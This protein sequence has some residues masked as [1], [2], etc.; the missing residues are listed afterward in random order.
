MT[1]ENIQAKAMKLGQLS[2]DFSRTNED[3][4]AEFL[5][6]YRDEVLE[7]AAGEI[8]KGKVWE[9][10]TPTCQ[11]NCQHTLRM[12]SKVIRSLKSTPPKGEI[13]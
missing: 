8:N 10:H 7:E 9:E 6:S 4:V 5:T 2:C 1:P 11:S 12:A 13:K 3:I